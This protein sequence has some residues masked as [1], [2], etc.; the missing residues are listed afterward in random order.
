M[1]LKVEHTYGR[2]PVLTPTS[3]GVVV[4]ASPDVTSQLA[5]ALK[6]LLAAPRRA[7]DDFAVEGAR[8]A[9]AAYD[10]A[11]APDPYAL[12]RSA[13]RAVLSEDIAVLGRLR[14]FHLVPG[15]YEHHAVARAAQTLTAVLAVSARTLDVQL[16]FVHPLRHIASVADVVARMSPLKASDL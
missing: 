15:E 12:M 2:T 16:Q 7:G 9:L 10:L 13:S 6:R 8:R 5:N 4:P 11:V 14:K 3:E 1:E